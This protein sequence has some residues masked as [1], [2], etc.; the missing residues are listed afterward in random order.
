MKYIIISLF[1]ILII[2]SVYYLTRLRTYNT[3]IF[4]ITY[5]KESE[6]Y[7]KEISKA[8]NKWSSYIDSDN[9]INIKVCMVETKNNVV[10]YATHTN[11]NNITSGHIYLSRNNMP[12]FFN[13][14]VNAITHEIGHV[15]GIGTH[16]KW[17]VKNNRLDTTNLPK[18][19]SAYNKIQ[20]YLGS[21]CN[22][23]C[24]HLETKSGKGSVNS[25]WNTSDVKDNDTKS[26]GLKNELMR[27]KMDGGKYLISDLTISFLGDVGFKIKK[28]DTYSNKRGFFDKFFIS[29][30][31]KCGTCS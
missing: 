8:A 30:D 15:L 25:H 21:K 16:K 5:T 31:Y 10:A 20:K 22:F 24:V 7:K 11:R 6:K 13:T 26:Y 2:I 1:I 3:G 27:Y 28:Y 14:R 4:S 12:F 17:K 18:T 23:N 19:L 9:L 29:T